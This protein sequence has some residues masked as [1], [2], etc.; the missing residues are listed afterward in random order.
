MSML[1]YRV[2][3]LL[4]L[5]FCCVGVTHAAVQPHMKSFLEESEKKAKETWRLKEECEKATR[6]AE[7]AAEKA[8]VFAGNIK[9]KVK[10]LAADPKMVEKTR[11]EGRELIENARKA[12]AEA[13]KVADQTKASADVTIFKGSSARKQAQ[14]HYKTATKEAEKAKFADMKTT[15]KAIQAAEDAEKAVSTARRFAD[16]A[17]AAITNVEDAIKKLDAEVTA[18]AEKKKKEQMK[19]ENEKQVESQGQKQTKDPSLAVQQGQT[20]GNKTEQTQSHTQEPLPTN[21]G[22]VT[23]GTHE[24]SGLLNTVEVNGT[25]LEEGH[26]IDAEESN[27]SEHHHNEEGGSRQKMGVMS[28]IHIMEE[29]AE[30]THTSVKMEE[31]KELHTVPPHAA[32][33]YEKRTNMMERKKTSEHHHAQE[34]KEEVRN[35]TDQRSHER[36]EAEDMTEDLHTPQAQTPQG[37]LSENQTH[38]GRVLRQTQYPSYPYSSD[39][40]NLR[41]MAANALLKSDAL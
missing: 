32:D 20:A 34:K 26:H 27:T 36:S 39:T 25:H 8:N 4:A 35:S 10:A 2:L 33:A 40:P 15:E 18:A 21:E 6:A 1:P 5:L 31:L 17:D 13:R 22:S 23:M 9:A 12:A 16:T 28:S 7:K 41:E 3:Y 24:T 19:Q 29:G 14:E 38:S 11:S 30:K 37:N